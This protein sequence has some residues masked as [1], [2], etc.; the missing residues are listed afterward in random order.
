MLVVVSS[1]FA[2]SGVFCSFVGSKFAPLEGFKIVS[3]KCDFELKQG[4]VK[5]YKSGENI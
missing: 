3:T 5:G 1:E 2:P 4:K